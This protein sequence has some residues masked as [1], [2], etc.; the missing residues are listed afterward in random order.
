[1][2]CLPEARRHGKRSS[3]VPSIYWSRVERFDS[4]GIGILKFGLQ[5]RGRA[6]NHEPVV[7]LPGQSPGGHPDSLARSTSGLS[8]SKPSIAPAELG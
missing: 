2:T 6:S 1:V 3:M 4:G 7:S 5:R 8:P